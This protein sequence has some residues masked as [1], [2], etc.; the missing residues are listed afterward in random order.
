MSD[1]SRPF[2]LIYRFENYYLQILFAL[3]YS[4]SKKRLKFSIF[5]SK[6][7]PQNSEAIEIKQNL[8]NILSLY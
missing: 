7:L 5:L 3:I 2:G 4:I 8:S 1:N 6:L